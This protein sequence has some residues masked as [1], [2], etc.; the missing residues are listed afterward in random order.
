MHAAVRAAWVDY[1]KNLEGVID[2]PYADID[3]WVTTGM[4]NKIDPVHDALG[5]PW[6]LLPSGRLATNDEIIAAWGAVKHD[7]K[8]AKL[9]WRY[10]LSLPANNIRLHPDAVDALIDERLSVND[11]MLK[12]K[13]PQFEEWPA[14][15]QLA[16]H[17]MV[18]AMGFGALVNKFPKCCRALSAMKF[19]V[20]A[21]ECRMTGGGGAPATGTLVTRNSLNFTLLHNAAESLIAH[22][23]PGLLVWQP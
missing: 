12:K 5:L 16:A 20:A 14:D 6:Y 21:S 4:G 13:F 23:D 18:W 3:N 17:S 7:P 1:N 9:G 19:A 11:L 10:A 8:C 15:A 22:E 2:G